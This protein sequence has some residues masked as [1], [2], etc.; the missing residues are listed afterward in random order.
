MPQ[1]LLIVLFSLGRRTFIV[2]TGV[3]SIPRLPVAQYPAVAPP[4]IIITVSYPVPALM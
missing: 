4:G 3:L 2:L 1:F